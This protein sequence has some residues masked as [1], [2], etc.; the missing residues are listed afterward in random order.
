MSA[1]LTM[2]SVG[3]VG[4]GS[5][6]LRHPA[7]ARDLYTGALFRK[8]RAYVEARCDRWYV[9]SAKHG[10]VDPDQILE[11][12][13]VRLGRVIPRAPERSALP[14]WDWAAM[15]TEQL[16]EALRDVHRPE[17]TVLAGEQYRTILHPC[18]WIFSEPMKG[19]G[20]GEQLAW[21]NRELSEQPA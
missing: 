5:A 13:D 15:V 17:L 1:N 11:P 12:Y 2:T 9:L 3:L 16:V 21:L 18:R 4:C 10:L 14:V 8:S 7:L 20:I 19:L 6:K